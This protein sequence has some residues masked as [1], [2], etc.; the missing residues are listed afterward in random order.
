MFADGVV[1]LVAKGCVT[2]AKKV[3]HKGRIVG[4]FLIGTKKLYDFVD[5]NPFIGTLQV[6][7]I[8]R[9]S[10][11]LISIPFY[12]AFNQKIPEM[13]DIAYVNNV[14]VIAK[15]PKMTAINSAIEVDLTGQVCADSIGTRMYSGSYNNKKPNTQNRFRMSIRL[16]NWRKKI[17][18]CLGFGGQVDFIRGAAE[19]FDG[20]GKPIIALPSA[21]KRNETKIVPAIKLGEYQQSFLSSLLKDAFCSTTFSRCF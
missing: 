6:C 8:S 12:V 1:D 18:C 16:E 9:F 13:L 11:L 7:L 14:G 20:K 10:F 3:I 2:N 17:S 15:N 4:S 5:N 19:G 21:T